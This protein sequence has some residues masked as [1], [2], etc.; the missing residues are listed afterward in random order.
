[1]SFNTQV[2]LFQLF[3]QGMAVFSIV[4]LFYTQEW[5]WL[6][7][8]L[9]AYI[10]IGPISIGMT[11]HRLLTHRTFETY[12]WIEN[13]LSVLT[14]YSTLGPTI[15]WVGLHR[16]HHANSDKEVDPHSPVQ[17]G[18][19]TAWTGIGWEIPQIPLKFVKDLMRKPIHKFILN[20]YFKILL[21]SIVVITAINP[22]LILF[23]Y[24][25]PSA[26]AFHGVNAINVLG[27]THGYRN[28]NTNDLSTNNL[29]V[30]FL[31]WDCLHNNHHNRPMDWT[32]KE[33]WFEIDPLSWII[34][35]IKIRK[36][37]A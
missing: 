4:Y 24:F 2:R 20:H 11:L 35:L 13:F 27:H 34:K 29:L 31:T 37:N 8:T 6:W 12:T 15:S 7:T 9:I 33:R 16:F 36:Q 32:N 30:H 19:F 17:H 23:V 26:L 10:V 25:L 1:M 5:S 14:V 22:V 18:W 21:G 28:H 3:V